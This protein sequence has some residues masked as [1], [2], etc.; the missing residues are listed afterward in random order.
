[1]R[2]KIILLI[3]FSGAL[4]GFSTP[5]STPPPLKTKTTPTKPED[6]LSKDVLRFNRELQ[7]I[8]AEYVQ[9]TSEHQLLQ[10]AMQGMANGLDPHSS[11]LDAD[12]LKDLQTATTGEFSG[13]GLEVAMEDGLLHVVTPIDDGPAQKAGIKSGDWILRINNSPIQG[14]TLREA[15]KKMR[16]EKGT[17]IHLTLIRKGLHKPI[18]VDLKRE[19]IRVR[20]VKGRLLEPNLAYIRI[21]SFQE[22]TRKDLDNLINQLQ[23]KQKTPLKGLIL[24]LRNNPGG[25]LTSASDVAN[26]FLDPNKM[27]YHHVIV[28]TQGQ[29]PEANM[30]LTAKP[31]DQIYREAMI[32]LIN[33]GSASGAEIVAGALQDNKRAVI[34]GTKSFGKGSVQT[35]IPLDETSALKLTTAL[36]YTPSGRSIQAA[37]I[38]PDITLDELKV[39]TVDEDPV[40]SIYLHESELKGHLQNGNASPKNIF[41]MPTTIASNDLVKNDYQL[42]EAFNLLKGMVVL[43]ETPMK[44]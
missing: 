35:V 32:V 12:D 25:L 8:K 41:E 9:P 7:T 17:P 31:N 37:G 29:T 34:L 27:G 18:T 39:S 42:F 19:T 36:Y 38:L 14:L 33:Q 2:L 21:S 11:F 40:D 44:G 5:F 13:L 26:A 3:L 24:D 4:L 1:M 23:H 10:N 6:M 43:Q 16:G 15:V 30:K 20:S 22:S 28:Y